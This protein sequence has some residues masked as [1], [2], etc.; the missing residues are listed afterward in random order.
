MTFRSSGDLGDCLYLLPVIRAIPGKHTIRCVDRPGITGLFTPRIPIIKPLIEAQSYIDKVECSEKAVDV[1]LVLFR[2]FHR[3]TATLV[4][5]QC[6]EYNSL[7]PEEP[8]QTN[9]DTP[10]LNV[11]PNQDFNGRIIIARSPRYNNSWFPWRKIVEHYGKRLLFVGLEQEYKSFTFINGSVERLD[12]K[13]FLELAQAISGAELFIGNQSSPQA[14]AMGLG[15][16]IIQEV[17]LEQPDCIF[18]RLNVQYVANGACKLPDITGSGE[19]RL[20]VACKP[21]DTGNRNIVPP[22]R[23]QYPELPASPHFKLQMSM[24][25]KKETCDAEEAD[26][27][28]YRHNVE[29]VPE[30]FKNQGND[31]FALFDQAMKNTFTTNNP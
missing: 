6:S 20:P 1:D 8:V 21:S 23:W 3:S 4:Q 7:N 28:L 17:C 26:R 14:V 24:V 18:N 30:F 16:N 29:R 22:G 19:L 31:P 27:L 10:W 9:G 25:M 2:H 15:V 11:E 5:A 13:D 12:V